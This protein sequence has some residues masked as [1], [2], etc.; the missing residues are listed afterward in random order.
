MGSEVSVPGKNRGRTSVSGRPF[1]GESA[2][3]VYVTADC[4]RRSRKQ[5][6]LC[7]AASVCPGGR[8]PDT[9]DLFSILK[10]E[11]LTGNGTVAT[12]TPYTYSTSTYVLSG[13]AMGSSCTK[14]AITPQTND[15]WYVNSSGYLMNT[16]IVNVASLSKF[17]AYSV[18]YI[19]PA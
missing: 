8:C 13:M 2:V 14:I 17:G 12:I 10:G 3:A 15:L 16:E 19:S 5:R 1:S 6:S 18:E 11:L 9:E 7:C 4:H